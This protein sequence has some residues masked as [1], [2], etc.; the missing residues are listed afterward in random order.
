M[1]LTPGV[2]FINVL[3]APF[4]RTDPKRVI[5]YS[6]PQYLLCFWDLRVQKLL[7]RTLMKLT[8]VWLEKKH[9]FSSL[10]P[11][12]VLLQFRKKAREGIYRMS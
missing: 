2:N 12:T 10:M 6:N 3:R 1:K 11:S 9:F 5:I 4:T 7:V 8:P